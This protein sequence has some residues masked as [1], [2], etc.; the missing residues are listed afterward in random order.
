MEDSEFSP[1]QYRALVC[2]AAGGSNKEAADLAGVSVR[3]IETWKSKSNFQRLL[4]EATVR[5]FDQAIAELVLGAQEAAEQLRG[6]ITDEETP[7][8]IKISAI[9]TLLTNASK[10]RDWA[11][12]ARIQKLEG[13]VDC[14]NRQQNSET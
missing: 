14:D 11:M 9:S 10:A 13:M 12:E 7:A 3:A 6:I 4:R 2:L 8:R 5:V 1:R